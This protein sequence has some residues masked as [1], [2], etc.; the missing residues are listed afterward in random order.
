MQPQEILSVVREFIYTPLGQWII[1]FI[2]AWL[3]FLV[4]RAGIKAETVERRVWL[5]ARYF[6][7]GRIFYLGL[8]SSN[9]CW[10]R[11]QRIQAKIAER[12]AQLGPSSRDLVFL[13][14]ETLARYQNDEL[15]MPNNSLLIVVDMSEVEDGG[16]PCIYTA[17]GSVVYR[18]QDLRW[19]S[20]ESLITELLAATA[21]E[22]ASE[23]FGLAS[24]FEPIELPEL[25]TTDQAVA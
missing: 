1:W 15:S 7:K 24:R 4:I 6:A 3:L 17:R 20:P 12:I 8:K 5:R 16:A 11:G 9:H 23:A 18:E 14:S 19:L 25:E 22:I 2:A 13:D 10:D 21:R